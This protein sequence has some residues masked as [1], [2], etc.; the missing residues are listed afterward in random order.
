MSTQPVPRTPQLDASLVT[1]LDNIRKN[2]VHLLT[3]SHRNQSAPGDITLGLQTLKV[4]VDTVWR[5]VETER[6]V[7]EREKIKAYTDQLKAE[8]ERIAAQKA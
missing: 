3:E 8:A 7:A 5:A 2:V 1:L 4:A 6:L